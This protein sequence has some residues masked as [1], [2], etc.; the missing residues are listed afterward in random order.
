M[1]IIDEPLVLFRTADGSPAALRDSCCHRNAPL[2]RGRCE[3]GLLRCMYHGLVFDGTGRC[4]L[5]PGQT[6]IP[7]ACRVRGYPTVE[8]EGWIWVWM[9]DAGRA[10][11]ALLPVPERFETG[12]WDLRRAHCDMQ[13]NYMLMT[14]NLADLSHVA[15][16]HEATFG[17]G[18]TRI[19][20]THPKITPLERSIRVVRWLADREK[21]EDWLPDDPRRQAA[22]S[23]SPPRQDLWLDYDL[24]A[25]GI[26]VMRTE[27]HLAGVAR[28]CDYG[29]P[30]T[31]PLHANLNIQAM[32]PVDETTTRH[33]F[34]LGPHRSETVAN[35]TLADDMFQVMTRG[36]DED[37]AMLEAQHRNLARW[38][39]QPEAAI[40]HDRGVQLMRRVVDRL[41][42]SESAQS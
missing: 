4:V 24:L 28:E 36:L 38:P 37:R 42:A 3:N 15:Y 12:D 33:F 26:F 29:P 30:R 1:K 17:G 13:A 11:P 34:A 14:D 32:T 5:I 23:E 2:S 40:R 20:E 9:G 16:L 27:I 25:P 7:A 18:D 6:Q 31:A 35:A 39:I 41:L 21:K 19:A 10:D 8:S 22:Q